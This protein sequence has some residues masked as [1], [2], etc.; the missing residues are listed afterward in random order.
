MPKISI[1][2]K[3]DQSCACE[4]QLTA[5]EKQILQYIRQHDGVSRLQIEGKFKLRRSAA[6]RRLNHLKDLSL[7]KACGQTRQTVYLVK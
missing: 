5:E 2:L 7:I 4:A 6:I 1:S 3:T